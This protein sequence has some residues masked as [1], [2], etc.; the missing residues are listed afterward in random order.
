MGVTP[1]EPTPQ[2]LAEME[3][4]YGATH[5]NPNRAPANPGG[6]PPQT[7]P[8]N[9][10]FQPPQQ[11]QPGIN[12][13]SPMAQRMFEGIKSF[14]AQDPVY[15][16]FAPGTKTLQAKQF[17]ENVRQ[18]NV[19]DEWK[20]KDWTQKLEE[21]KVDKAYKQALTDNV[22]FDNNKWI[23]DYQ[24][25]APEGIPGLDPGTPKYQ[26]PGGSGGLSQWELE[27]A[28][29][30][31][32]LDA[33]FQMQKD[34]YTLDQVLRDFSGGEYQKRFIQDRVDMDR[35]FDAVVRSY[36]GMSANEFLN[37]NPND[38]A[39]KYLKDRLNTKSSSSVDVEG[40]L[41]RLGG[42]TGFNDE[43]KGGDKRS[44][45]MGVQEWFTGGTAQAAEKNPRSDVLRGAVGMMMAGNVRYQ[46]GG[47]DAKKGQ[48]DCSSFTQ[49]IFKQ[50]G[51]DIG[52]DTRSQWKKGQQIPPDQMRP[53]DLVFFQGTYR[54]G[55]SH[56][57]IYIGNG[58][59]IHNSSSEKGPKNGSVTVGQLNNDYWQK[60]WLGARRVMN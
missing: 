9:P 22:A 1:F 24:G 11:T 4:K 37:Q 5:P 30:A 23:A 40:E 60:H 29:T 43:Q 31:N 26:P 14:Q 32:A 57:G 18:F 47:N 53:G 21:W 46:F 55:V 34:G 58:R 50:A 19:A 28:S 6:Y 10:T 44:A 51:V 17:D 48:L 2:W 3:S 8:A 25:F 54:P 15:M 59:F 27:S 41:N 52:R 35:L 38:K 20:K 56:V 13:E 33:A 42:A 7:M 16:P 12:W 36:T 49:T 45:L 39:A